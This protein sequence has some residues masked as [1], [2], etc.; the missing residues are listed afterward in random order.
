MRRTFGNRGEFP[1]ISDEALR[2]D[3]FEQKIY[4][5]IN[6]KGTEAAAV[7]GALFFGSIE[8]PAS[9]LLEVDR[10]FLFALRDER[11]GALVLL[12]VIVDPR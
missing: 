6:E 10:P 8:Q 12:G 1:G 7:T 2:L 5:D 11:S 9:F 4:L 3:D